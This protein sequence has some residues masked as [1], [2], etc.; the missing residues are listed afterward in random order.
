MSTRTK[1]GIQI[2]LMAA[3]GSLFLRLGYR[4]AGAILLG[5]ASV[6]VLLAVVAPAVL[7]TLQELAERISVRLAS[8]IGVVIL[9]LVYYSLFLAGS[10]WLR[11]RGRDPLDRRFPGDGSSNWIER[12]GY[13][14]DPALYTKP[15]THPHEK[16]LGDPRA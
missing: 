4:V 9:T 1:A 11:L 13:G 14:D 7:A 16:P 3:V 10:L 5:L 2:L 6:L 12:Q 15:Y 8:G